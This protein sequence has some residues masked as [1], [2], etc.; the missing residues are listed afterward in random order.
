MC[1]IG[2]CIDIL[3][4]NKSGIVGVVID[5]IMCGLGGD[6]VWGGVVECDIVEWGWWFRE[7]GV[8]FD[9]CCD[10]SSFVGW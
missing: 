5:D 1:G 10:L 6:D 8:G 9:E 4:L 3:F 2:E 7:R